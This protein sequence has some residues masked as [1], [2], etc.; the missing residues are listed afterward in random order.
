MKTV[1][2]LNN[3]KSLRDFSF[4]S[5]KYAKLPI[6]RNAAGPTCRKIVTDEVISQLY[7]EPESIKDLVINGKPTN[8][9]IREIMK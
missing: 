7:L 8:K 6:A 3:N 2:T 1:K 9:A 4:L 5:N